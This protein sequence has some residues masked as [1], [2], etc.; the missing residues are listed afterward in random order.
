MNKRNAAIA[1]IAI[2]I[3]G[4]A[5][6]S[7]QQITGIPGSPSATT[8]IQ[9]DQIPAPPAKFGGKIERDDGGIEAVL[10]AAHRSR[11]RARRTSCSS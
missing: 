5:S 1:A 3:L 8:T 10:A 7:A 9:G 4:S 11:P 2:A 6:L